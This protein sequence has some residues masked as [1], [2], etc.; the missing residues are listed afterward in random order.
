MSSITLKLQHGTTWS[1][2]SN[3]TLYHK[4][5]VFVSC[6][7]YCLHNAG[8]STNTPRSQC[9]VMLSWGRTTGVEITKVSSKVGVFVQFHFCLESISF[10]S[11]QT[12]DVTEK[13]TWRCTCGTDDTACYR[14][15]VLI[16]SRIVTRHRL[17]IQDVSPCDLCLGCTKAPLSLTV[18]AFWA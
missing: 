3:E 6:K 16:S 2:Q 13:P 7:L 15:S 17:L 5:Q 8:M 1:F 12:W 4:W 11:F 18:I 10:S 9:V 14:H